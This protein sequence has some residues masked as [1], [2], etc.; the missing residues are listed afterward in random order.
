METVNSRWWFGLLA[1]LASCCQGNSIKSEGRKWEIDINDDQIVDHRCEQ[2]Q[3]SSWEVQVGYKE[4]FLLIKS[5][6]AVAQAAQGDGGVTVP[7]GVQELC[8]CGTEGCGQRVW[9][10]WAG[11]NR[12][13]QRSFQILLILCDSM[14][15]H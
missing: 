13:S 11:W 5:G 15:V 8:G 1:M 3:L 4:K 9:W 12:W 6:E 2:H 10:G 14:N 7:G